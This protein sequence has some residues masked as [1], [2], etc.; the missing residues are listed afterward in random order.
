MPEESIS[1]KDKNILR[2]ATWLTK[3]RIQ[4]AL[5]I[6]PLGIKR[7]ESEAEHLPKLVW[8]L[9]VNG[10]ML[11]LPLHVLVTFAKRVLFVTPE[12]VWRE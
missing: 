8:N 12:F 7:L 1:R 6:F 10:A 4:K 3:I 2:R 11:S 9:R 5:R